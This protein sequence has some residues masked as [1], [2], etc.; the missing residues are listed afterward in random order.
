MTFPK[1]RTLR[2]RAALPGAVLAIG[3]LTLSACGDGDGG[4]GGSAP[5]EASLS[6]D[7]EEVYDI[8]AQPADALQEGGQLTLPIGHLGPNFNGLTNAGNAQDTRQILSAVHTASAWR[9]DPEGDYVLNEDYF[10]SAEQEI[11]DDGVQ[12]LHYELNPEAVWNDGTPIDFETYEHTLAIRSGDE[13]GY[14]LVSTT[15]YDQ[16][17]SVEQGEDEWHFTITMEEMY[18]PWQSI[19]NGGS[20][21]DSP[22]IHP[23]VDTP[24]E[25]NDGFVND[26]RPEFLAGPFTVDT[27]DLAANVISLVPNENWWGE[28][29]VLDRLNF[30]TYETS[31]TIPAFQNGEIDATSV[32][33]RPR[34][35]EL[36]EWSED[37]YDI[38]RGQR[39]ATCGFVLNGDATNLDDVAV[40][41]AIFRVLDRGQLAAIQFEGINWDEE[42][43]GSWLMM[44]FDERYEDA[45]PVED[46]DPEGAEEVLEEAGWTFESDD[47]EFRSRD[48]EE[49]RVVFNTFGDDPINQ[50]MVQAAQSMAAGAGMNLDV[51]NQGSGQFGEVVGGRDF[52]LV[53]MCYGKAG[54]DPTSAPNQF[55]STGDGNLTGLG[56]EELD[57]R[58]SELFGIED[59]DE[60]FAEAQALEQEALSEYFHY[61][62]YANGPVITA[63]RE[64]LANYGPSLFETTDWTQVGWE[65]DAGHDGTDTGVDVEELEDTDPEDAD[66]DADEEDADEED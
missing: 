52:G 24:E 8:N 51:N 31:A 54:A 2:R 10:L 42:T 20:Q 34:Y 65:D 33:T 45:Y 27:M 13:E 30:A 9:L 57:D 28:A 25:F 59:D 41:E 66:E 21:G 16:V 7:L 37:G 11:T 18:Q 23:D 60:R 62:A 35:E 40:R 64:G 22:I 56:N 17:E 19:F 15:A 12:L 26:V 48:G 44:P 6:G 4:G 53:N 36:T 38:R 58:I 49:L 47:D 61:L 50:A 39:M 1:R 5:D 55:Y 29:P 14:D 32:A 43:P 63:F 3:A 46:D